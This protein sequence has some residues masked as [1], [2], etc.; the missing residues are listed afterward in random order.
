[1]FK[2]KGRKIMKKTFVKAVLA[3]FCFV[4]ASAFATPVAL[5]GSIGTSNLS[6]STYNASYSGKSFLPEN[7]LINSLTFSFTFKDD[8][9]DSY[10]SLPATVDK[11]TSTGYGYE[12]GFLN[13]TYGRDVTV[14][15]SVARTGE[16]ETAELSLA[17]I[18]V[19]SGNTASTISSATDTTNARLY[20]GKDC[21]IFCDY[22]YSDTKYITTTTTTDWTGSF[23]ISGTVTNQTILDKLL[24]DDQLLLSLKVG[25]DLILTSSSLMLDYTKVEPAK[26]PE[27]STVMLSLLGLAGL[28]FSRRRAK[29]A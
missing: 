27:P 6:N 12:S 5:T 26:V 7:Y 21:F 10:T 25:G 18:K 2:L 16:Q 28:G 29:R 22:Y 24:N 4:S 15:Q 9:K 17:G 14:Y 11:T 23:T 20:D 1:L 13:V 19:G 3:A 8:A